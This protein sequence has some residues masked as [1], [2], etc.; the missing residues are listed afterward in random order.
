VH[1]QRRHSAFALQDPSWFDWKALSA[2]ACVTWKA[3]LAAAQAN[4]VPVSLDFNHRPQLGTLSALWTIVKPHV[5][6][7]QVLILST[8]QLI[9]LCQLEDIPVCTTWP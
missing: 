5:A 3:L 7:L 9:G 8:E 2:A 4:H 1:F 6:D